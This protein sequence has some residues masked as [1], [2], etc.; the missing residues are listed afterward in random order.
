MRHLVVGGAADHLGLQAGQGL[1]VD[2][3]F[4]RARAEHV[5]RQVVDLVGLDRFG[6]VFLHRVFDQRRV[7]VGD[8]QLG[9]AFLQQLHVFHADVAQALHGEAVLA[10]LL[11][12]ELAVQRCHQA[13]QGAIGGERG[14][15]AGTA[16]HLVH[17]HHVFGLAVDVLHVVDVGPHVFGGDVAA[18]QRIHVAAEAAEQHLGLVHGAVA[19]DH[20]LAAADV[21]AGQGVLVGHRAAQPQRVVQRQRAVGIGPH[22]HAA[23][24][25][26]QHGAVDGDDGLQPGIRV[27]AEDDLFVAGSVEGFEDHGWAPVRG[28]GRRGLAF[29][30]NGLSE[31][32]KATFP[33]HGRGR[34][35]AAV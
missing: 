11:V 32:K 1:L 33:E 34:R 12:A 3:V 7:E 21:Q 16:V 18:A 4:Q 2:R 15:I 8:E 35:R 31:K 28:W 9:A 23:Q 5:H 22:A 17:A 29:T 20:G 10:D 19:D 25:R 26:A 27:V 14:R 13:L 24:R 30:A 6:A